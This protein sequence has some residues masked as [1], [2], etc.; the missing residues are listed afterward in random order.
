ML[1][2]H[3]ADGFRTDETGMGPQHPRFRPLGEEGVDRPGVRMGVEEEI[4]L[5]RELDHAPR[6]GLVGL[7]GEEVELADRDPLEA[8]HTVLEEVDHRR[9]VDPAPD[10]A[11]PAVG[12]KARQDQVRRGGVER[13]GAGVARARHQRPLE[14]RPLQ[15]GDRF[16]GGE[17]L[18][19]V[20]A[21][22]D[23]G[24]EDR[25]RRAGGA[26]RRGQQRRGGGGGEKATARDH[27]GAPPANPKNPAIFPGQHTRTRSLPAAAGQA[28]RT[29]SRLHPPG[30]RR[31]LVMVMPRPTT[32]EFGAGRGWA[33]IGDGNEEAGTPF[34]GNAGLDLVAGGGFEPP[35]FGL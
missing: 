25:H 12:A 33:G 19:R 28:P 15:N 2:E 26:G 4:V 35:T 32:R 31:S 17:P 18:G 22:M 1:P 30:R 11:A 8:L 29:P 14:P 16:A 27:G 5:P 21:E 3:R 7:P 9:I 34:V 13:P 20:V 23:M 24:V 10:L 6:H